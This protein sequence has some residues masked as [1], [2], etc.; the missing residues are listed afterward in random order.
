M[1]KLKLRELPLHLMMLPAM[2][3]LVVYTYLPMAGILMAFQNYIPA[4]GIVGSK[5]I[6]WDNFRYIL[7][8]PNTVQVLWNTVFI[9]V[10]KIAVGFVVPIIFA[11]L[12]NEVSKMYLK[13]IFQTIVYLP[14][15]LSWVIIAGIAIDILSPSSGIINK[16]LNTFGI[17]SIFFLGDKKWFPFILVSTD[18]W[19]EFGFNMILY[20]AAIAGID[21]GI[22]EAAVI[23]GAGRWKQTLHVTLPGIMPIAV[24]ILILGMGNILNAGFEQVY[25][26]YSPIVYE[27]GDIID[28][29]V[30]RTGIQNAQFG[31]ATALGLFKSVVSLIFIAV[32]YKLANKVT[33]YKVL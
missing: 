7:D 10:M 32:S 20:L 14:H 33:G 23:D 25:N 31:V 29:L 16:A 28:T 13:R 22:Y 9:A 4:K 17:E 30:Y 18:V 5:W 15:F 8:M 12:L 2:I 24:L 19:K 27:T 11:L 3:I 26:L 1:K 6:G 21:T